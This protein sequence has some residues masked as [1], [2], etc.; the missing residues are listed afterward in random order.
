MGQR[1]RNSLRVLTTGVGAEGQSGAGVRSRPAWD[2]PHETG[3]VRSG[4]RE[5]GRAERAAE[6]ANAG[7]GK[8]L[9]HRAAGRGRENGKEGKG[10]AAGPIP[11]WAE[12]VGRKIFQIKIFFFF[13]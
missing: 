10:G 4:R 5:A 7:R 3:L 13:S 1:E 9:G 12:K 6:Q 11:G 8:E 2:G